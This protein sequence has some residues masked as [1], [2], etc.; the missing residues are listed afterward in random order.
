MACRAGL[1]G[2]MCPTV[3]RECGFRFYFAEGG[4]QDARP[5]L[6]TPGRRG[7]SSGW[8]Q[9]RDRGNL[10]ALDHFLFALEIVH[11]HQEEIREAWH[12]HFAT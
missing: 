7:Q 2:V 9:D 4:E 5:R 10:G 6:R 8:R 3:F 12:A 11:E 1:E